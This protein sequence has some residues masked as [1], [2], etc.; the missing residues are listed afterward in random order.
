MSTIAA[1]T[2][3]KPPKVLGEREL[4]LLVALLMSLNALTIDGM[5]PALGE[6]ATEF[7]VAEGNDRQMV[8]AIYLLATGAGSLIPGVIADRV[9]RRPVLLVSLIGYA[10][11]S[12]LITL[13]H[14]FPMLLLVRGITGLVASGLMVAPMAIIRDRYEGDRMARLMSLVSAVFITVPVIA[15]SLGQAVLMVAGWRMIFLALGALAL[16]GALWAWLR[17]PETLHPEDRQHIDLA[18]IGRNMRK[19]LLRRESI[20][21]TLGSAMLFGAVFG[22]V[23][24]A[25]QL[26][27]EHFQAGAWFP[28]IFGGTA[29]TLAVSNIINSRIVERFGARRVSHTGM[30]VFILV[31]AL[32]VWASTHRDGSLAWFIPLMSINLMLL[33]FL[34]ANFTSIAMQPFAHLAGA[35]SSVQTFVR[36]SGAAVIGMVIGQAYDG[37]AVPF[38]FALLIGSLLAFLFVLFSERGKLFNRFHGMPPGGPAE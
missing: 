25:Q 33:G 24:S 28:L 6:M 15:P 10:V 14:T 20:G 37:T 3:G 8:V 30:I 17:L 11:L 27:G 22:Y 9:G 2:P 35:A 29:A 18:T 31:S 5:L 23:N 16:L 38:A 1:T 21:Y 7:G 34:G 32:Q 19:S 26:I 13:V 12:A 36:M 4:V